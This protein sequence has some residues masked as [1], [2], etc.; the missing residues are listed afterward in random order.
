MSTTAAPTQIEPAAVERPPRALSLS[1]WLRKN[2]FRSWFD[3]LLTII[4]GIGLVW[5]GVQFVRWLTSEAQ[6]IVI[7]DNFRGIMQGLYP[8][9]QGWRLVVAVIMVMILAGLSWGV[10]GRVFANASLILGVGA[11]VFVAIPLIDPQRLGHFGEQVIPL[12]RVLQLPILATLASLTIGYVAGRGLKTISRKLAGRL[13]GGLW[14]LSIPTTFT[15]VRG[16]STQS[17]VLPIVPT[18]LWGGLLLTFMMAFIAIVGSFP[19]GI[20]LALGRTSSGTTSR[21]F[22]EAPGLSQRLANWW[23]SQGNYPIIK[24]FCVVYIEFM[25]GIP[26]V[27]V[28]FAA[29]YIVPFA[30]GIQSNEIDAAVKAMVGLT[31]FEAAYIAEIVRGGLQAIPPGQME[32]AKAVGLN[33]V[34]AITLIVLPQAL[35]IVI[36]ALVGQF[37]TMFKDTSLVV[38]VGLLELLGTVQSL[39]SRTEY[40]ESDREALL[41]TALVYFVFS[42]GMSLAARQLERR[43]AGAV[44]RIG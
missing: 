27:T 16:L 7:T 3:T 43:G 37:I 40:S 31:L 17:S 4:V 19:I 23:R 13:V 28:F 2:L 33:P 12:L 10:W 24:L 32:A 22:G 20:L 42:Y 34:Q 38:L 9:D 11:L 14:L 39:V 18:H 8:I 5:F 29:N 44:R 35:R 15:L 1:L 25:R 30:L 36:P 6:W 41:F 21:S 26:L